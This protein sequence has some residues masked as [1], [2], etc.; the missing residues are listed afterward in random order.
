MT[1]WL[2]K[3]EPGEYSFDDLVRDGRTTWTGVS[4][5]AAQQAMRAMTT[6]DE[7]LIYH[8]GAEKRIAGLAAVVRGAYPD[9]EHPGLTAK[10]DPKRVLVDL[11][12]RKPATRNAT[13]AEIKADARFERFALVT[14]SRLSAMEV[15]PA[16]AA[17]LRKM[18]GLSK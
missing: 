15:P 13:L 5:P 11:E 14:Q 3:T 2:L 9:P 17:A 16:L 1:T 18:A 10:G 6:G 12:P 7:A 4:N 8:T